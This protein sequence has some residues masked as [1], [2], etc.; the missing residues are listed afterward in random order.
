MFDMFSMVLN[1]HAMAPDIPGWRRG[2]DWNDV[3][4]ASLSEGDDPEMRPPNLSSQ[5]PFCQYPC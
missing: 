5:W 4:D 1:I 2:Y 3:S